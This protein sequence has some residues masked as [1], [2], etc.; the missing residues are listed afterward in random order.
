M[1]KNNSTKLAA[2]LDILKGKSV[3]A[4]DRRK[5]DAHAIDFKL[6]TTKS[7]VIIRPSYGISNTMLQALTKLANE[8][9]YIGGMP[10]FNFVR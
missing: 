2:A 8:V 4:H 7:E 9:K 3:L 10:H 5:S 1:T 6:V